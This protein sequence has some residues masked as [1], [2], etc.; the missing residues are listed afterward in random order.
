MAGA[1]GLEGTIAISP[2]DRIP[3]VPRQLFKAFADVQITAK[4]SLDVDLIAASGVF[5]RGN[6]NN[7]SEPDGIYYL[8]PG[9]TPAYGVVNVGGHYDL[10]KRVQLLAQIDNIFNARY[11]TAAQLGATG[12]TSAG[13]YVARPLPAIGGEFPV[14]HATFY[15]PGAPTM[16]WIGTRVRF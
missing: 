5:A 15:A 1:R 11:S 2:G 16:F 10:T 13:N 6:E 9:S 12:F 7:R 3:L 8:G 4:M 14:Q